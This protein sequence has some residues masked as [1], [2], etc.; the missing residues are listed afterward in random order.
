MFS[1]YHLRRLPFFSLI[2]FI[3]MAGCSPGPRLIASSLSTPIAVYPDQSDGNSFTTTIYYIEIEVPDTD[4]ALQRATDLAYAYDGF[5]LSPQFW[6]TAGGRHISLQ[7][8]V[9]DYQGERLVNELLQLGNVYRNQ[10]TSRQNGPIPNG[11]PRCQRRTEISLQLDSIVPYYNP[12]LINWGSWRPVD[13]IQR[14]WQ[15]FVAIFSFLADAAIWIIV[16]VGPFA[17]I[18]WGVI[19]LIRRIQR[20]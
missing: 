6:T 10:Q 7:I 11:C 20:P 13:T 18:V 9:P 3:T 19:A 5:V 4:A 17:L 2:L 1:L 12:P 14:A 8:S 16:V 15:V